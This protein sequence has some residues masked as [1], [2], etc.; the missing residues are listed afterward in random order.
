MRVIKF[1]IK[2]KRS[3]LEYIKRAWL[4]RQA[5]AAILIWT[6]IIEEQSFSVHSHLRD[7]V[8]LN[9]SHYFFINFCLRNIP[10]CKRASKISCPESDCTSV[11][12]GLTCKLKLLSYYPGFYGVLLD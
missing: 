4:I 1:V 7:D 12:K 5:K 8:F 6:L 11:E 10:V 2:E 9:L 3:G